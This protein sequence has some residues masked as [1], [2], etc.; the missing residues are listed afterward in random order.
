LLQKIAGSK[1]LNFKKE[2]A[3]VDDA[4]LLVMIP[5]ALDVLAA[6]IALLHSLPNRR[7]KKTAHVIS[8]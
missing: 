3:D 4:T 7:R 2:F 1:E 8:S 6:L 5:G